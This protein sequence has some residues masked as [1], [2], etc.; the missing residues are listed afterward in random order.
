MYNMFEE[1]GWIVRIL[2][3]IEVKSLNF[4]FDLTPCFNNPLNGFKGDGRS[5]SYS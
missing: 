2:Y 3:T 4:F 1:I 5:S